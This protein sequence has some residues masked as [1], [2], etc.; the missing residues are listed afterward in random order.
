[1]NQQGSLPADKLSSRPEYGSFRTESPPKLTLKSN[2]CI[3]SET[4]SLLSDIDIDTG[5][6]DYVVGPK[7]FQ[8]P[9]AR[10]Q[11]LLVD[12]IAFVVIGTACLWPWNC[13]LS[14]APYFY[15]RFEAS[16]YLQNNSAS[17]IM[18]ISTVTSTLSNLYLSHCH[19]KANYPRRFIYANIINALVFGILTLSCRFWT[20]ISVEGYF[21]Y[22]LISVFLSSVGACLGQNGIFAILH[23]LPVVYT[24]ALMVGQSIAGVLPASV[25]ILSTLYTSSKPVAVVTPDLDETLGTAIYFAT[26]SLISLAGLGLFYMVVRRNPHALAKSDNIHQTNK[27]HVSLMSLA[28]QLRGPASTIVLVFSVTLIFPVFAANVMPI[29]TSGSQFS[30]PELFVPL[31]FLVWNLGDLTGRS[32]CAIQSLVVR[33]PRSMVAYGLLRFVFIIFLLMCNVRDRGA[34]V[35]SDVFYLMVLFMFGVTSGHLS[36]SCMMM[37]AS[38]VPD[39][40]KE[41]AGGFMILCLSVGLALGSVF[42]F[43]FVRLIE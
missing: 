25:L 2:P 43:V 13:F 11:F 18:T 20:T 29:T 24:Q 36:S 16:Q 4:H 35:D 30:K 9:P 39:G 10:T 6:I 26:A 34:M 12:Y 17:F 41:A 14:A 1:M 5:E 23:R 38:F 22:L 42:S 27:A 28:Q 21:I 7:V 40:V 15:V 19:A 37:A 8:A 31:A 3:T 32:L 33:K